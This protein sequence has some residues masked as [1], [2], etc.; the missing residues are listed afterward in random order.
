MNRMRVQSLA[1]CRRA[2]YEQQRNHTTRA[3]ITSSRKSSADISKKTLWQAEDNEDIQRV[4][5]NAIIHELTKQQTQTIESVVPWFLN[6]MPPGYFRQVPFDFR[7]NHIK[8]ISAVKDANMDLHMNLQSNMPDGG[9]VLTFI[10]P[11]NKG[12]LLDLVSD[13]SWNHNIR[14]YRPLSRVQVFAAGDGSMS[15]S[16]FIYGGEQAAASDVEQTG[17]EILTYAK[18]IQDGDLLDAKDAPKPNS[19]FEKDELLTYMRK[20]SEEYMTLSHPRRF[21][22]QRELYENVSQSENIA[23][24][25]EESQMDDTQGQ[26]WVDI[27]TANALPH[28]AL[29]NS[30]RVLYQHKLDVIR[31]HLDVVSDGENGDV[32]LL[33]LLVAPL[34]DGVAN[35]KTFSQIKSQLKRTKWL[36]PFTLDLVMNKY[37]YLGIPRGEIITAFCSLIHPVMAKKNSFVFSKA[38]I[39]ENVTGERS[40][41]HATSIA[42]LFMERFDPENPLSDNDL[43]IRS[44]EIRSTIDSSV[45]DSTSTEILHKM[46]DI[47]GHTL[48]TNLYLEN[49]YSLGLRLDPKIM[50]DKDDDRELPFGIFF[51]HGRRFNG[52][53]VRFRDIA[54]GGIRLVTPPSSEQYAL[55]SARHFDECYSLAYA[56]QMKNK[57]I[58]EGGSKAVALINVDGLSNEGKDFVMRKCVKAFSDTLL[59]LIVDTEETREKMVDLVGRKEVLYLGPDE[60]VSTDDIN[61][62]VKRAAQRGYDTPAAFMS[63][64]P[65][66]GINHKVYGVTSE[67][68][69]VYLDVALRECLGLDPTVDPFTIKI[70]GGPDGDVGGNGIKILIREYGSNAKIVGIADHSGCAEDPEG[71]NHEGLLHLVHNNL[72]IC[73]FD[74]GLLSADGALHLVDTEEGVKKRNSMHNRIEADAFMP[75]GGRPNTID[76]NNYRQFLKENGEPSA[77]LIVEAANIFITEEARQALYDEAGVVIVKDSSANKCG[78]MTSSYEICAAMMLSED[79]FTDNKEKIVNEVLEKLRSIARMEAQLLFR[80]FGNY[81]GSLPHVSKVVSD[82]INSTNDALSLALDK[83]SDD[84]WEHLLPLFRSHLPKTI[85][86]LSFDRVRDRVPLQYIKNAISSS[87]ASRIVYREGT[88]FIESYPEDKLAEIALKYLEKEKELIVLKEALTE[89]NLPEAEKKTILD[90]LDVGGARTLL[91]DDKLSWKRPGTS[92]EH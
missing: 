63:S 73:H 43:E 89:A 30:S 41:A 77:P 58:P 22:I 5:Q 82:T 19:I 7:I 36:D 90:L 14:G 84:E 28:V 10:R 52:Y 32:T 72:S 9:H 13:L 37:P 87:L 11:G 29:E 45:E 3:F 21:L 16:M 54:R 70:T 6:A 23:V 1:G 69:H 74:C 24:Y 83:M 59:D 51:A 76:I 92:V 88:K 56:Q 86:D 79:E 47:V 25:I 4:T 34:E 61:W 20:C 33:R 80:E 50:M 49:R 66:V 12:R 31:S 60:Q 48:K 39:L 91:R 53:H 81:S 26:Y 57:D 65:R 35:E 38:N 71:L 62:I 40:I 64:K 46:C 8:A 42:D 17:A 44:N 15:L 55:E 78:V 18:S 75:A 27:A 2:I 67:G 85:S 68:V